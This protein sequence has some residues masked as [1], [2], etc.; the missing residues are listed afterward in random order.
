MPGLKRK[1]KWGNGSVSKKRRVAFRAFRRRRRFR[2]KNLRMRI[3]KRKFKP[4]TPLG[5]LR[6]HR[7]VHSGSLT[8]SATVVVYQTYNVN[9]TYDPDQTG[10]GTQPF[11]R[12]QMVTR[13]K[14]YEVLQCIATVRFY[15]N[16]TMTKPV[17]FGVLVQD[18]SDAVPTTGDKASWTENPH[19]RFKVMP[20]VGNVNP[21]TF[22][23]KID[24]RVG[25]ND[26]W[27]NQA[28]YGANPTTTK[29]L[30]IWAINSDGTAGVAHYF[31]THLMMYTRWF[32]PIYTVASS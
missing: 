8:P 31:V 16:S 18:N 5:E 13:Y 30:V 10:V 22:K 32:D 23:L 21:V 11:G 27:N 3:P 7:W 19:S 28:A 24:C 1:R 2:K 26:P 6:A 9:S 15:P 17:I 14:K 12:D 25:L 29:Q 20:H 4:I